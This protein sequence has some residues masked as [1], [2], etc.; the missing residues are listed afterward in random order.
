MAIGI[1]SFCLVAMLGLLPVGLTQ[2]RKSTDQMR[3]LQALE[4]VMADFQNVSPGATGTGFY[5]IGLP[6][7]GGSVQQGGLA[8][9]ANFVQTSDATAKQFEVMYRVEPPASRFSNYRFSVR[10]AR[11]PLVDAAAKLD[12]AGVDYVESVI[13]KPAL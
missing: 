5:E 9:D 8:L 2:E 7:V 13:L 12:T 3:S 1:V 11:T 4:A 6:A 10:V